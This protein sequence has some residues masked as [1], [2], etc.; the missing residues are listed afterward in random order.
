MPENTFLQ[1]PKAE[2][3]IVQTCTIAVRS[4]MMLYHFQGPHILRLRHRISIRSLTQHVSLHLLTFHLSIATYSMY[5]Q[6][7]SLGFHYFITHISCWSLFLPSS[8]WLLSDNSKLEERVNVDGSVTI[9]YIYWI[10][11]REIRSH[12]EM[13]GTAG[14]GGTLEGCSTYPCINKQSKLNV[15]TCDV[16]IREIVCE[17]GMNIG[18]FS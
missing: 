1:I 2:N 9:T 13:N 17:A 14:W 12:K 3:L 7:S 18:T 6:F 8:F 10:W 5:I 16:M 15:A 4:V 11:N